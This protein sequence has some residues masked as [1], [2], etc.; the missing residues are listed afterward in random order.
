MTPE[1]LKAACQG[2]RREAD[3]NVSTAGGLDKAIQQMKVCRNHVTMEHDGEEY[4]LRLSRL[5]LSAL[6]GIDCFVAFISTLSPTRIPDEICTSVCR[7]IYDADWKEPAV[8]TLTP[9]VGMRWFIQ[10]YRT[11]GTC[12]KCSISTVRR[13][14]ARTMLCPTCC[15]EF[16]L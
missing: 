6:E 16:K 2:L 14:D 9:L 13:T 5:R 4:R 1:E 12:P 15:H 3:T 7:A 8:P 11:I 10:I